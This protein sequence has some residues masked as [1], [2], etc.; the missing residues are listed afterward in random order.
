M[1]PRCTAS[2]RSASAFTTIELLI[3]A[4][5]L[6]IVAAVVLP[7]LGSRG[8]LRVAAA[9]RTLMS[10]LVYAQNVA[11]TKQTTC[12]VRFINGGYA[13]YTRSGSTLVA[14]T[15]PIRRE[16]YAATF[17]AARTSMDGVVLTSKVI[18]SASDL[19]FDETGA[20]IAASAAAGTGSALTA[21]ASFT[22]TSGTATAT[23]RI[24]PFTGQIS[25]Q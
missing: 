18:D 7:T 24:E 17:G 22:L 25:A 5:I 2:G 13:L 19:A 11:I 15:H 23:V 16:S 10:D 6:A 8:S 3:V 14:V 20:P 4:A 12:Y 9:A 1:L 21:A